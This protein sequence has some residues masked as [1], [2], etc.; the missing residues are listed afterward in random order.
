[1]V[2]QGERI[3]N[4]AQIAIKQ[5]VYGLFAEILGFEAPNQLLIF[6][7]NALFMLVYGSKQHF[8]MRSP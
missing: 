7:V 8:L 2:C 4:K 6:H 3:K 5:A 1:M